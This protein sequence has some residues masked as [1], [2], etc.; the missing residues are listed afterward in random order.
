M[1]LNLLVE[2]LLANFYLQNY[3]HYDSKQEE[4]YSFEVATTITKIIVEGHD[5]MRNYIK[6]L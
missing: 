6:G 4:N 3:L 1:V 2:I 5:N